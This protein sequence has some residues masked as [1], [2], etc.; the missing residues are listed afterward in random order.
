M[1]KNPKSQP[2]KKRRRNEP[3]SSPKKTYFYGTLAAAGVYTVLMSYLS[4][5]RFE[6]FTASAYDLGI[7][8]QTVWNTAHGWFL[9]DS[10]NMGYPMMRFWMAHWEFIYLVI[11]G[12]YAIFSS[13]WTILIFQSAVCA[14]GAIPIYWLGREV[15]KNSDVG[16]AFAT[17]YL[18][19]PVVHNA[20]LF[21]IHGVTLAAP[22]LIYSFYFLYKRNLKYF[23]IFSLVALFCREDSALLLVMMGAYA[24]FFMKD[25]K[26]GIATIVFSALWF[27]IW[28]KR[29][30]IRAMLGLP[31]FVIMEGAE[32]HWSHM[33]QTA[34]DILYPVKF[35]AKK[36]NI[37]YFIFLFG[38]VL[39]LS[40]FSLE[41]ALIATPIFIINLF[42]SYYY[43]HNIEHYYSATITPFVFVSAIF[44]TKRFLE[45][46]VRKFNKGKSAA[47]FRL[48]TLSTITTLMVVSSVAFFFAK[49][50]VFDYKDWEILPHH[51]V[52]KN[53]ID[54]I[55]ENA[56]VSALN[57]LVP[58]VFE[59]HELYVFDD[60]IDKV[61]Y[62]LYDFYAK[63]FAFASRQSF[64]LPYYW[65]VN[66][67]IESVLKDPNYGV[68]AYED[69]VCLVKRGANRD[70]GLMTLAYATGAEVEDFNEKEIAEEIKYIG[71]RE[72]DPI[73]RGFNL[74]D[75]HNRYYQKCFHFTAFWTAKKDN[76][77]NYKLIYKI[78]KEDQN[79]LVEHFP[80]MN[81]FPTTKWI[82]GELVRDEVFW[83]APKDLEK[84][85]YTVFVAV[86]N[87]D[88]E[89]PEAVEYTE[90][91]DFK[92]E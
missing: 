43:T 8:F 61:D 76:P 23:I 48:N 38:P 42:S 24:I 21:D 68:V 63:K 81:L 90:I 56:S 4:I 70:A 47:K 51:R 37:E 35:L 87:L 40:F 1:P 39:F 64:F 86:E 10:V 66:E 20:N 19:Y 11:A 32:T 34:S 52:T 33:S 79:Y 59:R 83:V 73:E 53:V 15:F 50:N 80:V 60:N 77:S 22:F 31:E 26:L 58:H 44:G 71:H 46:F 55:P 84:G 54:K 25:K 45:Y 72:F 78:Q 30:E 92:Y 16:F 91:F 9:Q 82:E 6:S 29:M 27:L 85:R 69:G 75:S 5:I 74:D 13:P 67:K 89:E 14:S 62:I 28:Y 12:F 36:H 18:L 49:S 7:M 88:L 3:E 2:R 57:I 65:P 41:T 17:C